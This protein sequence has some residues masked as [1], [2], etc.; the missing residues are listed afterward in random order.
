M[1]PNDTKQPKVFHILDYVAVLRP[2]L[3]FPVWTLLLLG[4]HHGRMSPAAPEIHQPLQLWGT[5]CLYSLLMGAVYIINQI[6]DRETDAHNDKL[7]L[8]AQGYVKLRILKWQVGLLLAFSMLL[9]L[10]IFR[11][12]PAYLTLILLSISLGF[13]YSVRPIRLKGIPIADLCTNALGYGSIAFLVGWTTLTPISVEA[14]CRSFP[15]LFSVAA[16]FVNTTLPDIKG[17][18]A[19]GDNTTGV[20]LG[21]KRACLLSLILLVAAIVS[22]VLFRDWI[23]GATS[24]VCLPVFIYMNL[25]PKRNVIIWATRIGILMLSLCASVLFPI[26]LLWFGVVI[27]AT[28]WYY[29]FRFGIRYP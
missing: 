18:S 28:R 27:F 17:D 26:Y 1:H 24:I 25:Y 20:W 6:A 7:Y 16:A 10:F 13:A 8:V 23:A 19:S 3:L 4:Y 22:A 29:S 12:N 9:S 2:T 14:I 15:Y 11:K 21:K 5:L